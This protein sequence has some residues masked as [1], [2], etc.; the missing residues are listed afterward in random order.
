MRR[1]VALLSFCFSALAPTSALADRGEIYA[2]L[3]FEPAV[4]HFKDPV[5]LEKETT[6]LAGAVGITGYFGLTNTIHLGGAVRV[7]MAKDIEFDGITLTSPGGVT[8]T[9]SV[10][11]DQL[12]FSIGAVGLYRFDTGSKFAPLLGLEGGVIHHRYSNV[13]QYPDG[14]SYGISQADNSE[15]RPYGRA[16]LALEYRFASRWAASAGVAAQYE[17][18]SMSPWQFA[19]PMRVGF[20]W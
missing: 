4:I 10:Y 8:S 3:E 7:S 5:L 1:L 20:I 18:E 9:G 11:A 19:F 16:S 6:Q 17:P 13:A 2:L 12:S 14:G 15:T